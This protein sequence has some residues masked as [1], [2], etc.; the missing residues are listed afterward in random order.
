MPEGDTIHVTA[1][2][3]RRALGAGPL[4]AFEAPR[5]TGPPP[6]PGERIERIEARGKHLLMRFE[7]GVTL[8]THLGMDGSWRI[9]PGGEAPTVPRGPGRS[10][11]VSTARAV[12]ICRDAPVV[13]L[14]DDI[15]LRLH[16]RLRALGPDLCLPDPDLDEIGRRLST[17]VDPTTEIGVALLDQRVAAGIGNVYRSEVLWACRTDPGAPVGAVDPEIHRALYAIASTMLRR[18]LGGGPRRTVP[19]GLA[20]YERTRRPC[21]R[22]GTPIA[23]RR[24]GEH[25]RTVWWCPGCQGADG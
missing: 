7:G 3:L 20:V 23:S 11:A 15:D 13:E 2:S 21:R 8:H 16:P 5:T 10:A 9:A 14:L 18:N 12:A 1:A 24:L 17:L 19:E 4:T 22:C 25:A 6:R